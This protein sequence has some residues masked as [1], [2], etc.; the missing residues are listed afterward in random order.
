MEVI[1]T[2][3]IVVRDCYISASEEDRLQI[4]K[5]NIVSLLVRENIDKTRDELDNNNCSSLKIDTPNV[6]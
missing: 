2:T 4:I 6:L 5:N 3:N 1:K